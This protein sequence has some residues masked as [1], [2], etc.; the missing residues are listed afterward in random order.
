M[1]RCNSFF[2]AGRGGF[3]E[4]E[5]PLRKEAVKK[6][7]QTRQPNEERFSVA[8]VGK[9]VGNA[10]HSNRVFTGLALVVVN[11]NDDSLLRL[12]EACTGRSIF[13]H[14]NLIVTANELELSSS[15]DDAGGG[16][17]CSWVAPPS[18]DRRNLCLRDG[19]SWA[20]GPDTTTSFAAQ[21]PPPWPTMAA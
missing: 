3:G 18:V 20:C 17:V 19:E 16:K 6:D 15:N 21:T 9:V 11:S 1:K 10:V 5:G 4:D 12:A 2:L 13:H 8:A 7:E 14:D